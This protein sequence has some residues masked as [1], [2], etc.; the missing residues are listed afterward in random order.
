MRKDSN[1]IAILVLVA[2]VAAIAVVMFATGWA[3]DKAP[4]GSGSRVGT[5]PV[6]STSPAR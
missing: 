2:A 3:N 4:P 6:S 1:I 5:V